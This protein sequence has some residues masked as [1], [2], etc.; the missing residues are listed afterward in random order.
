MNDLKFSN[1]FTVKAEGSF[2]S[3][4][5][6]CPETKLH[7]DGGYKWVSVESLNTFLKDKNNQFNDG[8]K[9]KRGLLGKLNNEVRKR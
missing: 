4:G 6:I 3:P 5:K 8:Q 2:D 1:G 9:L 7:I